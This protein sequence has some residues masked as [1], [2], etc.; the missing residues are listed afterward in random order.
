VDLVGSAVRY[1]VS[2][3]PYA[4]ER[5]F[6]VVIKG[7]QPIIVRT[8]VASLVGGASLTLDS[9]RIQ[10]IPVSRANTIWMNDFVTRRYLSR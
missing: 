9:V 8:H 7:G 5:A 2:L 4:T 6:P 10:R 3:A 1:P